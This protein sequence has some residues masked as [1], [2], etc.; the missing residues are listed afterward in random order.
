M[1]EGRGGGRERGIWRWGMKGRVGRVREK[2]LVL[3]RERDT[4]IHL[5]P[6]LG[7]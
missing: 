7:R 1:N 2:G 5:R 4:E 3:G 6:V